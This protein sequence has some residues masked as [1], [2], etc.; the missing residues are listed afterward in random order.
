[1]RF[2]GKSARHRVAAL[3][4]ALLAAGT[5]GACDS[6]LDVENPQAIAPEQLDDRVNLNLLVNGVIGEFQ[7]MFDGLV[8][9][10]GVF[11]DELRN[12][13]T[14]FEEGLIDQRD[15]SSGNGTAS[16]LVYSPLQRTRGLADS[17]AVRFQRIL[18]DS[19]NS[20]LRLARVLAY[21]G[22]TYVLMAEHLCDAPVNLS[23]PYSP[24]ELLRDF[25][26]PRFQRAIDVANAARAAAA[27]T[28]PATTTSRRLVA[29]AD[30]VLSFA[31]VGAAR[32]NLNLYSLTG[33]D[34]ARLEAARLAAQVPSNFLLYA[35]YSDNSTAE[36]N[37]V[38][39]RL[40]QST[41]ASVLGTPFQGLLDPRVPIP[42]S[43][44]PRQTG[45]S[46]FAPNSPTAYSTYSGTLPGAEFDRGSNIRVASGLEAR[47]IQAEAEGLNV[48]NLAFVNSRRAIGGS[49]AL[50]ASISPA[51][52]Q[53]A[54]R[55]QRRID[56]YLDGH[57]LGDLRRYRKQFGSNIEQ[58]NRFEQGPYL[59]STT[60][61]FADQYCFPV[62][63]SEIA[64][65]PNYPRDG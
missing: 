52:F 30:S 63:S 31:R 49:P 61:S 21:G 36:N 7:S 65:N 51:A 8:Y 58:L 41:A 26:L 57:R 59:E 60:V 56:L 18:G 20:D 55:E 27:A 34:A 24:E 2:N 4:V 19:A 54:L 48:A 5:L 62:N 6:L 17:T 11:S 10:S 3:G 14:F 33:N 64:G 13:F 38:Y 29:G 44:D 37:F 28:S 25:A 39:S 46:F 42:A 23:R 53:A 45:L 15:V 35:L 50:A 32:A 47:Y 43:T 1:M 9:F 40:T 22:T 16:I 12:H